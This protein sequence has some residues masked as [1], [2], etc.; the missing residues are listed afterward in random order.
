MGVL[1]RDDDLALVTAQRFEQPAGQQHP[2]PEQ[3][4]G[5]ADRAIGLDDRHAEIVAVH[6]RARQRTHDAQGSGQL[7]GGLNEA[8]G[9]RAHHH[10]QQQHE[11]EAHA[12]ARQVDEAQ[13]DVALAVRLA[14]VE[15]RPLE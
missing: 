9:R 11:A 1:V 12:R 7:D 3:A 5:Q 14:V 4:R 2:G 13:V 6:A 15:S 10:H 8:P